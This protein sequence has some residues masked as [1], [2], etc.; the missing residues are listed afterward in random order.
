M[1]TRESRERW[2]FRVFPVSPAASDQWESR[3]HSVQSALLAL[4]AFVESKVKLDLLVCEAR[5]EPPALPVQLVFV[6][7]L[8]PRVSRASRDPLESKVTL[9]RKV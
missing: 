6:E 1:E 2:V 4:L 9:A 5:L 7:R 3:D 8:D